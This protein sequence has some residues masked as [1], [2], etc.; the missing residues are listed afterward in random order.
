MND[1]LKLQIKEALKNSIRKFF[2][3]KKVKTFHILDYVFPV[4][5]RIRSLIGGLETSLGTTL[6]EPLA[7]TIAEA[8]GFQI[9]NKPLFMPSPFPKDIQDEIGEIKKLR[10]SK[11]EWLSMEKCVYRLRKVANNINRDNLNYIKPPAGKGVD[12]YL[13]KDSIEYVF[14]IKTNQPNQRAGL[15]LNLQLLEWYAYRFC[16]NP[17]AQFEARIAFPFNPYPDK[18]WWEANGSRI[19]PLEQGKDAWVENEF[20]NFCSGEDNTWDNI[21]Q[22]FIELGEENFGQEFKD[23]FYN[24]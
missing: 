5:R 3:N 8:N 9:L 7:K 20:W 21:V 15:D 6:W 4:E 12:L 10:E 1:D 11:N 16:Q 18:S 24:I 23:I 14:D 19:Y 2:L 22:L 17:S 13:L